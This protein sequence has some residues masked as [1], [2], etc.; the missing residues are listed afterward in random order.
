MKVNERS[1]LLRFFISGAIRQKE[2]LR[3]R[4]LLHKNVRKYRWSFI[5]NEY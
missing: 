5:G 2:W 4:G 3:G 1:K